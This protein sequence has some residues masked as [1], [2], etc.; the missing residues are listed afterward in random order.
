M[1]YFKDLPIST[2]LSKL[3]GLKEFATPIMTAKHYSLHIPANFPVVVGF[4]SDQPMI[5]YK[6]FDEFYESEWRRKTASTVY[7]SCEFQKLGE[8]SFTATSTICIKYEKN[9]I[10]SFKQ[11]RDAAYAPW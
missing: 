11:M 3:Y 4:A 8:F 1:I 7:V 10:R 5:I 2:V 6:R 9:D